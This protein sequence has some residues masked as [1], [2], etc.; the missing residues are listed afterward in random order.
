VEVQ[1]R[2]APEQRATRLAGNWKENDWEAKLSSDW[3]FIRSHAILAVMKRFPSSLF[4]SESPI[5][6]RMCCIE[7]K[8][9]NQF[10]MSYLFF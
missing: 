10:K 6:V 4:F 8:H 2:W 1:Q 3:E 5:R 9:C 7:R